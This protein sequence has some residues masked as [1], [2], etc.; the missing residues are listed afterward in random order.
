MKCLKCGKEMLEM[1]ILVKEP[2]MRYWLCFWCVYRI[3]IRCKWIRPTS[4]HPNISWCSKI[5]EPCRIDSEPET[6]YIYCPQ[7]REWQEQSVSWAKAQ[8]REFEEKRK[9]ELEMILAN[10]PISPDELDELA[11]EEVDKIEGRL[12]KKKK[13]RVVSK[14]K[15]SSRGK[16]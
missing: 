4:I 7:I 9:K 13:K 16:G 15:P 6:G 5:D 1:P 12:T 11:E 3:I 2:V 10:N 8:N 14:Y